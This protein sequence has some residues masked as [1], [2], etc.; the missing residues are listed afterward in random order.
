MQEYR[1][2]T[3][4]TGEVR[5]TG[6]NAPRVDSN[7]STC[8]RDNTRLFRVFLVP[9]V[10]ARCFLASLP[11]GG[12]RAARSICGHVTPGYHPIAAVAAASQRLDLETIDAVLRLAV[13]R[14]NIASRSNVAASDPPRDCRSSPRRARGCDGYPLDGRGDRAPSEARWLRQVSAHPGFST[15]LRL[16]A[17]ALH[18]ITKP[19]VPGH[20]FR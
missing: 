16:V 3:A 18:A 4:G 1:A 11:G 8:A 2:A 13:D 17:T 20:L 19:R 6:S 5:R 10:A 14:R 15:P 7:G 12:S 9:A